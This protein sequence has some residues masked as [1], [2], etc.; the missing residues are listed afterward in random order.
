[1]LMVEGT[2]CGH[3]YKAQRRLWRQKQDA[4]E[5]DEPQIPFMTQYINSVSAGQCRHKAEWLLVQY[6]RLANGLHN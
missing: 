1:M 2:L 4:T 6:T 5:M 3:L